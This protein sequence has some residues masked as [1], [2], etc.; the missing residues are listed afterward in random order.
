MK[1][2]ITGVLDVEFRIDKVF[3]TFNTLLIFSILNKRYVCSL[4]HPTHL[5]C[6]GN[7]D[8]GCECGGGWGEGLVGMSVQLW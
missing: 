8:P 1:T 2:F 3:F 7:G 6:G 5:R 4:M